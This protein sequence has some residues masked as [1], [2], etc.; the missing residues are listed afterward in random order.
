MAVALSMLTANTKLEARLKVSMM[1]SFFIGMTL[2]LGI[3]KNNKKREKPY[4]DFSLW[5]K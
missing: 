4:Q 3:T 1:I 2:M 5:S